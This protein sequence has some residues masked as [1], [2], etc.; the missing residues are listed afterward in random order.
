MQTCTQ[1]GETKEAEA[2][3]FRNKATGR[4]QRR[5]KVCV[6]GYGRK[7]YAVHKAQ[8]VAKSRRNSEARRRELAQQVRRYLRVH[9]C[10]DCGQRDPLVL[11]F[12]HVDPAT[13]RS[14]IYRLVHHA[15]SWKAVRSEIE[16]CEVRCANCHHR[17]T[18][19]QFGWAKLTFGR[20]PQPR[21]DETA[22]QPARRMR[23]S[24]IVRQRVSRPSDSQVAAD[25]RFCNGCGNAKPLEAFQ[26]RS[27]TAQVRHNVCAEC[28]NAY[29]REHYRIY[30]DEYVCRNVAAQR[31]RRHEW[32]RQLWLYLRDHP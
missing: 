27:E 9:P 18:A 17:R 19:S 21:L 25:Q 13:K 14:T 3:G 7:H 10:V 5:C 16:K 31:Q 29:R 20:E 26:F 22:R 11:E 23:V 2:F 12:D 6:G 30:R 1:C 24:G 8:Y 4:R 32:Q 15:C 28:F